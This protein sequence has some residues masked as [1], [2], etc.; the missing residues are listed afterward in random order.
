MPAPVLRVSS[1]SSKRAQVAIWPPK[2]LARLPEHIEGA[3]LLLYPDTGHLVIVERAE[4]SRETS[5]PHRMVTRT[6]GNCSLERL[7]DGS[8]SPIFMGSVRS[9]LAVV[10]G[11]RG[12]SR[13]EAT[14]DCPFVLEDA[15]WISEG[16]DSVRFC[17]EGV[18]S[19]RA[20][21]VPVNEGHG[22]H[23]LYEEEDGAVV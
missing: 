19:A 2:T 17:R 3:K 5:A 11:H 7:V 23:I 22:A 20:R 4:E 6:A 12:M 1:R 14:S 16:K 13:R 10:D 15:P 21:G 8:G 18:E 9:G